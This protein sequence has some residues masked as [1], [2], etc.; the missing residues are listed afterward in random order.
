MIFLIY[1]I[2]NTHIFITDHTQFK[3]YKTFHY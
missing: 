2:M 3:I 1:R